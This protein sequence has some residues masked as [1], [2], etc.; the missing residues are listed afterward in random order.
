[1]KSKFL[2][3]CTGLSKREQTA[4]CKA[5]EG[6]AEGDTP[7]LL[8]LLF[9]SK[10]E[11]RS[12][13]ARER[14][15]DAVTD[16]LSFPADGFRAGE[17]ILAAEHADCVEP[18]M[19]MRKGEWVR[20]G[21]HLYLGSVVICTERAKEQAEEYGHSYER[22]LCYLAVHGVLHCLGYDHETEEERRAMREKEESVMRK[23]GLERV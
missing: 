2:L 16:V 10:E 23:L 4:L 8:E 11:I 12:L 22:E 21:A 3:D 1:M 5:L 6:L 15:V 7:L 20:K 9:V 14:G 18:V 17:P 19:G 13:N